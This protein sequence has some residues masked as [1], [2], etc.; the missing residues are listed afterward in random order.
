[1]ITI[2]CQAPDCGKP[3]DHAPI[4]LFGR[5]RPSPEFCPPCSEKRAV[6]ARKKARLEEE[7]DLL[8]QWSFVCPPLYMDSDVKRLPEKPTQQVL[9]WKF[10]PKGLVLIGPTGTGKTR[11]AFLLLKR[12]YLEGRSVEVFHGNRFGHECSRKFFDNQGEEWIRDIFVQDVVFFDDLGKFKMTE[13]VE[14]ELFSLI[15]LRVS[16]LRPI[17][18]TTNFVG[19][20][21]E[22]KL[23]S[24]RGHPLVRRLR[25]FCD[26]V[27]F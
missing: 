22:S 17:I 7:R 6:E 20:S 8:G 24:D 23:T 12:L 16:H 21:L 18:V 19:E 10:N 25:E 1:M 15:E 26:S 27:A 11:A 13:R 4:V 3:F 5:E 2:T 14:A 9:A